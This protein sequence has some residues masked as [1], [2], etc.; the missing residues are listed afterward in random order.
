M[1]PITVIQMITLAMEEIGALDGAFSEQPT[2]AEAGRALIRLNLMLGEWS[3][4]TLM[5]RGTIE[6]AFPLVA[7][8][9]PY[10]IGIGGQ[11]NTSKPVRVTGGFIRDQYGVDSPLGT[12][13]ADEWDGLIDKLTSPARPIAV[14][15]D[16]GPTQQISQMGVINVY[17]PP[18]NSGPYTMFLRQDKALTS[19][20]LQDILYFE[21]AYF[22]AIM[23]CLAEMLWRPFHSGS[24]PIPPDILRH[25]RDAKRTIE[26]WNHRQFVSDTGLPGT[27]GP[28]VYDIYNDSYH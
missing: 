28:G 26:T 27:S 25:A 17:Y 5:A 12:I 21:D 18:D 20:G 16:P 3:G 14:Y 6:E 19:V 22:K 8:Q 1:A 15:Y 7:G 4:G 9:V 11:F 13:T 23:Y 24:E 10:T 2:S